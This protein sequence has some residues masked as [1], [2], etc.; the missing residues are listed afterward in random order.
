MVFLWFFN[1]Q[2]FSKMSTTSTTAAGLPHERRKRAHERTTRLSAWAFIS[3]SASRERRLPSRPPRSRSG[4]RLLGGRRRRAALLLEDPL[5]RLLDAV[6]DNMR[7]VGLVALLVHARAHEHAAPLRGRSHVVDVGATH[8]LHVRGRVVA[9]HVET[10]LRL[11]G[12]WRAVVWCERAK[13]LLDE[14]VGAR[15][16][17]A[18]QNGA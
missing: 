5:D 18:C 1:K 8:A 12:G 10:P 16:G 7:A 6:D 4:S 3:G 14:A 13:P 15:G 9:H 17:L 11:R 2:N